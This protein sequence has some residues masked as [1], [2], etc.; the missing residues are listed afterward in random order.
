MSVEDEGG[1]LY[2]HEPRDKERRGGYSDFSELIHEASK[3]V[4]ASVS[5]KISDHA[6][7]SRNAITALSTEVALVVQSTDRLTKM[8]EPVPERLSSLETEVRNQGDVNDKQWTEIT[9]AKDL[10]RNAEIS[11]AGI[12]NVRE[13][14][15][16][17][18]A[19]AVAAIP[20]GKSLSTSFWTSPN[21]KYL[22]WFG[23]I[24]VVTIAALAG[25]RILLEG[26]PKLQ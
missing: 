4:E 5:K 25:E 17:S 16:L 1:M 23:I 26:V 22:I 24:I 19:A 6:T 2:Q 3:N 21:A 15:D 9:D 8:M 18:I 12:P 14:V 20:S 10:A 11:V 7:E 13:T